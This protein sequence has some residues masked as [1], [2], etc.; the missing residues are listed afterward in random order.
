MMN[1]EE[2]IALRPNM[3]DILG[4][5]MTHVED[6]QNRTL[7]PVI[8]MQHDLILGLFTLQLQKRKIDF[9]ELPIT[10]KKSY[11]EQV[12]QKDISFR[13]YM[14]GIIVGQFTM[15]E[16]EIYS[17]NQSE[18]HKRIIGMIKKRIKDTLL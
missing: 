1:D 14:V 15:E 11:I 6:F 5:K 2:R 9:E 4:V 17:I 16:F 13:S 12:F 18:F 10:K 8:K 7:R 3:D